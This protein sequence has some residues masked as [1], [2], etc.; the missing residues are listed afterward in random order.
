[1]DAS[2]LDRLLAAEYL[3]DLPARPIEQ[4]RSMRAECQSVEVGLSYLRRLAQGRLDIVAAELGRRRT[5]ERAIWPRWSTSC[6]RSWP[7]TCTCPALAGY[8]R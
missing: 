2:P 5:G 4:I 7:S 1:M 3:G 6:P 8:P